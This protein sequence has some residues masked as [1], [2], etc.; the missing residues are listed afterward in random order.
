MRLN[1]EFKDLDNREIEIKPAQE[2][3]IVRYVGDVETAEGIE[4]L[5]KYTVFKNTAN[6]I[7]E[8]LYEI[9]EYLE[10]NNDHLIEIKI[11]DEV[12]NDDNKIRNRSKK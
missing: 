12:I 6:E 9:A 2:G 10:L 8:L 5:N 4:H 7:K 3:F 1:R 11:D